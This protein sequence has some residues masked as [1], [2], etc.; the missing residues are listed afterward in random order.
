MIK[1]YRN[2][3][4]FM[5]E[6]LSFVT[7]LGCINMRSEALKEFIGQ[8]KR[9]AS[10]AHMLK[11]LDAMLTLLNTTFPKELFVMSGE[12]S[13][14][15][16]LVPIKGMP[17]EGYGFFGWIRVGT[18]DQSS[19]LHRDEVCLFRLG[20]KDRRVKLGLRTGDKGNTFFYSVLS[21]ER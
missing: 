2:S 6:L 21:S 4:P 9:T 12:S 13:S 11:T 8:I 20:T 3:K 7:D 18:P 10:P 16:V 1:R 14:G 15:I 5:S 17:K 19:T